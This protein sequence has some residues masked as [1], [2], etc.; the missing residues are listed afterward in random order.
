MSIILLYLCVEALDAYLFDFLNFSSLTFLFI[1]LCKIS[2]EFHIHIAYFLF[3]I[4]S[5]CHSVLSLV[6]EHPDDH[7][8]EFLS[9]ISSTSFIFR[10]H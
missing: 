1:L 8:F 5:S 2:V 7:L 10:V 9:G 6:F 4:S 3:E